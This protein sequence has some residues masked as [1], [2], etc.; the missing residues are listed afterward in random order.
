[1]KGKVKAVNTGIFTASYKSLIKNQQ[2]FDTNDYKSE[3][4]S[5][6]RKTGNV[7]RLFRCFGCDRCFS[8]KL[9]SGFLIFCKDC[10]NAE[11]LENERSRQRFVEKTLTKIGAFLRRRV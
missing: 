3:T 1:M 7:I 9:M 8:A 6:T 5:E 2:T 11:Q 10:L 4:V